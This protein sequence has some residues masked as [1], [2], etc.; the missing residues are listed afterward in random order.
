MK[1]VL[2]TGSNG[3]LGQKLID[4]Y[5]IEQDIKLI[6]TARGINRYPHQEGY[7]YVTMDISSKESVMEVI[8]QY[9]P[10][11]VINTAA[12]TNVD[13]CEDEKER[14]R[15]LN[16]DA[17]D[18]LIEACN[19]VDAHLIHLS[20]DFI[21]DGKSGPYVEDDEPTPVSFYG[22]S[23]LDS[24]TLVREKANK[25][26]IVRTI[27]VYGLVQ[28]MS[29]SNIVLWAKSALEAAKPIQVVDDQ[30]RTPTLAEDLAIGCRLV[31]QQEA[32]GI[33][34]ISGPDFMSIYELVERVAAYYKLSTE[35]M[36][37]SSS[38]SLNQKAK[39]PPKTGFKL[40]K[41]RKELGYE[42]RSLE[43]GMALLEE[44]LKV[45]G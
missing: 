29:R 43:E 10:D 17:V 41:A 28:D 27:L 4:I 40:D 15:E 32:E 9:K 2:I 20:T 30:F 3:L 21:F 5:R 42:P 35:S 37:P 45:Y 23:K 44:Q 34:H 31:E 19:A 1:T 7:T 24:E 33:F 22:Q 36:S 38:T 18:Y 16:V 6:A 12:M 39:R 25:W 14:C 26:S 8:S 13:Q 11:T